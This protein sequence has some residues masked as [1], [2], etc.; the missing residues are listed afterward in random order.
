[1]ISEEHAQLPDTVPVAAND[2]PEFGSYQCSD[3]A[4]FGSCSHL[5][6]TALD[7]ARRV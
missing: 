7:H 6:N 5:T 1:M 4:S 3:V 2:M